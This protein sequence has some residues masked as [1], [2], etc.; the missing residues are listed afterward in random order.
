VTDTQQ[1]NG[2]QR[3]RQ[4]QRAPSSRE[5]P[6]PLRVLPC[7]VSSAQWE[8]FEQIIDTVP[9]VWLPPAFPATLA[10]RAAQGVLDAVVIAVERFQLSS[11]NQTELL[12]NV[13]SAIPTLLL[14]ANPD[15]AM[16]RKAARLGIHSVLPI[17]IDRA[18]LVIAITAIDAGLAVTIPELAVQARPSDWNQEIVEDTLQEALTERETEVL[19]LLAAGRHNR[20]IAA[21][22]HISEHTAKFHVSS[23]LAK[24]RARSRTEAVRAGINR[25]L[26][27]I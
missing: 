14:T 22:L 17:E 16:R 27:P 21:M 19:R 24:L 15:A 6:A 3:G 25:G 8:R 1:R 18:Q 12:N 13:F 9:V 7:V 4:E 20:E 23:I 10:F 11:W 26:V 2:I 5:L